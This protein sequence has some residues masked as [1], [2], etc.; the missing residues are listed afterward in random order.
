M[1]IERLSASNTGPCMHS[2]RPS[3]PVDGLSARAVP[4]CRRQGTWSP[5]KGFPEPQAARR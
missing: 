2:P 4:V 5:E 3:P 1:C